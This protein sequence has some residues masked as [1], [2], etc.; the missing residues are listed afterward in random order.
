LEQEADD[1]GARAARGETV[2]R[3]AAA[4]SSGGGDL[5]QMKA[6]PAAGEPADSV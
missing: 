5:T 2:D 4:S 6:D 3:G 1:L